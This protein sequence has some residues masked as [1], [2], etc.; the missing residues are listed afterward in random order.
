MARKV[1][2][3][4]THYFPNVGVAVVALKGPL[5]VGKEIEFEKNGE[6]LF[7]QKV[8]SMQ[9][10]HTV[11]QKAKKGQEIGLKVDNEVKAGASVY[12]V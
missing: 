3:K 8:K 9:I 1:I 7:K 11:L 5:E 12:L 6:V 2:G 10:E 4:V